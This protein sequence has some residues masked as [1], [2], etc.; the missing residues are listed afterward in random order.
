[1][2][3]PDK[4]IVTQR[5]MVATVEQVF[6][7]ALMRLEQLPFDM[8]NVAVD[9]GRSAL[10]PDVLKTFDGFIQYLIDAVIQYNR[11]SCALSNFPGEDKPSK[12]YLQAI[13]RDIAAAWKEFALSVNSFFIAK[14]RALAS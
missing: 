11:T 3:S 5:A 7:E 4:E 8:T 6:S 2:A 9:K 14:T 10:T 1:M 13:L 12:D